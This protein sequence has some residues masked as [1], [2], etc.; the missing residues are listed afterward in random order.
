MY[1]KNVFGSLSKL[2]VLAKGKLHLI[3]YDM[4]TLAIIKKRKII[5]TILN[6]TGFSEPPVVL[7]YHAFTPG[8]K[9][10]GFLIQ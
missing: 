7:P 6:L 9:N 10:N 3:S 1:R 8:R 2:N 5:G 4:P